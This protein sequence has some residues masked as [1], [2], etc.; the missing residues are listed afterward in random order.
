MKNEYGETSTNH[1]INYP[2]PVNVNNRKCII[3]K[4]EP[5]LIVTADNGVNSNEE[6][7]KILK[8]YL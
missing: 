6:I 4:K 1:G 2:Q 3:N 8:V 7:E 5:I